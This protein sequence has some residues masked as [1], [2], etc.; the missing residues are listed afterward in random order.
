MRGNGNGNPGHNRDQD[1]IPGLRKKNSN[2]IDE[3]P[4][5]KIDL[6]F[7]NIE[8]AA[9]IQSVLNLLNTRNS[10]AEQFTEHLRDQLKRY[11]DVLEKKIGF[12]PSQDKIKFLSTSERTSFSAPEPDDIAEIGKTK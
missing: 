3:E 9:F 7:L 12:C 6:A 1:L 5:T 8:Q 11:G 4:P 2:K 10:L